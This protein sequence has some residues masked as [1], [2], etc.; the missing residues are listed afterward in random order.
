MNIIISSYLNILKFHL[1]N[2]F[3]YASMSSKQNND[4]KSLNITKT[5]E[6]TKYLHLSLL[7]FT[8]ITLAKTLNQRYSCVKKFEFSKR[9]NFCTKTR[10]NEIKIG[11]EK[12][13]LRNT[14]NQ[15]IYSLRSNKIRKTKSKISSKSIQFPSKPKLKI[16]LKT[17]KNNYNDS[18]SQS[19]SLS[20]NFK[21]KKFN[22]T[23]KLFQPVKKNTNCNGSKDNIDK[24]SSNKIKTGAIPILKNISVIRKPLRKSSNPK[25]FKGKIEKIKKE[26]II[27]PKIDKPVI[28]QIIPKHI[29]SENKPQIKTGFNQSLPSISKKKNDHIDKNFKNNEKNKLMTE[30]IEKKEPKEVVKQMKKN[31]PTKRILNQPINKKFETTYQL[32]NDNFDVKEK[33]KSQILIHSFQDNKTSIIKQNSQFQKTNIENIAKF[34]KNAE[35]KQGFIPSQDQPIDIKIDNWHSELHLL[36]DNEKNSYKVSKITEENIEKLESKDSNKL[37]E[38]SSV[39]Y[40]STVKKIDISETSKFSK[41]EIIE[42]FN[43]AVSN[44]SEN[45]INDENDLNKQNVPI[46]KQSEIK[47]LELNF[48]SSEQEIQLK[49][50]VLSKNSVHNSHDSLNNLNPT[51][52]EL[53]NDIRDIDEF[54][55]ESDKQIESLQNFSSSSIDKKEVN[56]G[57]NEENSFGAKKIDTCILHKN[58]ISTNKVESSLINDVTEQS[59]SKMSSDLKEQTWSEFDEKVE[60]VKSVESISENLE[61]NV[62]LNSC[63]KEQVEN[64]G[65]NQSKNNYNN[66]SLI[67]KSTEIDQKDRENIELK[68]EDNQEIFKIKEESFSLQKPLRDK[69]EDTN[70]QE[71]NETFLEESNRFHS[72]PNLNSEDSLHDLENLKE[73]INEE[74]LENNS[75]FYH[76]VESIDPQ[77]SDDHLAQ[78]FENPKKLTIEK[79]N[80]DQS[81]NLTSFKNDQNIL[82]IEVEGNSHINDPINEPNVVESEYEI[83][84]VIEK[85]D[86]KVRNTSSCESKILN[87]VQNENL[88]SEI[89]EN[90]IFSKIEDEKVENNDKDT[91]SSPID[92]LK[93]ECQR[94][95]KDRKSIA[96]YNQDMQLDL[97]ETFLND[98]NL[99]IKSDKKSFAELESQNDFTDEKE[100]CRD[101]YNHKSVVHDSISR[102]TDEPLSFEELIESDKSKG[103]CQIL[104]LDEQKELD[105]N[106]QKNN[107]LEDEILI[108]QDC[109]KN[110]EEPEIFVALAKSSVKINNERLSTTIT[111]VIE[112]KN[113]VDF[114]DLDDSQMNFNTNN[115]E[116]LTNSK[117]SHLENNFENYENLETV[118]QRLSNQ[119]KN[120]SYIQD[121]LSI[122]RNH[123]L[124][125]SLTSNSINDNQNV[126][127][128]SDNVYDHEMVSRFVGNYISDKILSKFSHQ[129]DEIYQDVLVNNKMSQ[130]DDKSNEK[131]SNKIHENSS[132]E[133]SK[134][135]L[136]NEN[137]FQIPNVEETEITNDNQLEIEN[138]IVDSNLV[139]QILPDFPEPIYDQEKL[140]HKIYVNSTDSEKNSNSPS[141]DFISNLIKIDKQNSITVS[142]DIIDYEDK[143]DQLDNFCMYVDN[144]RNKSEENYFENVTNFEL[145]CSDNKLSSFDG[146]IEA[147]NVLDSLIDNLEKEIDHRDTRVSFSESDSNTQSTYSNE[148]N[149]QND[150]YENYLELHTLEP[151]TRNYYYLIDKKELDHGDDNSRLS[152]IGKTINLNV[153]SPCQAF[154]RKSLRSSSSSTSV[155]KKQSIL[156]EKKSS[157]FKTKS[158]SNETINNIEKKSSS[159]QSNSENYKAI[160]VYCL[161]KYRIKHLLKHKN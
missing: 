117:E 32:E 73:K 108:E 31:F 122:T 21:S 101:D 115:F 26:I 80:E 20:G 41:L 37:F 25:I 36:S 59:L 118:N 113:S 68:K 119:I 85:V 6:N 135:L 79:L 76:F 99:V 90:E 75:N 77:E 148:T 155:P 45:S 143:N 60:L 145:N 104:V 130:I 55:N 110:I 27:S 160:N 158:L 146:L 116:T 139:E 66:E 19:P 28:K 125:E 30:T 109:T 71:T 78:N 156:I 17:T 127:I 9:T 52:K 56:L 151:D 10:K 147:G 42:E 70:F 65:L 49:A 33:T 92:K 82:L 128:D 111:S 97:D 95:S 44:N 3:N 96:T 2:S 34:E 87:D 161:L 8:D 140:E 100:N 84:K 24:N 120:D 112:N 153:A 13:I 62:P 54:F 131:T 93:I 51:S 53:I 94:P 83:N 43:Q 50:E 38:S 18:E 5:K 39:S 15:S 11:F 1:Q 48:R 102:F 58:E 124:Q 141:N 157:I 126:K 106:S 23:S 138:K 81:L 67:S 69:I 103:H 133:F 89:L 72:S 12:N 132:S 88:N 137:D 40:L 105:F 35:L 63:L 159:F 129:F 7:A 114:S 154:G 136:K 144:V 61:I 134:L 57:I 74:V 142:I 91:T 22:V 47:N 98:T 14:C 4:Q 29:K 123:I 149:S 107:F 121:A 64:F 46:M 86:D 16:E 152:E 150:Y